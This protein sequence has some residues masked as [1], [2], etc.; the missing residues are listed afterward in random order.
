MLMHQNVTFL[1]GDARSLAMAERLSEL[2]AL[3]TIYALRQPRKAATITL[4]PTL[5]SA[6]QSAK[7]VVLPMPAFDAQ[8]CV[9]CPL[10]SEEQ[11]LPNAAALLSLI[12][13]SVPVF[14]GRI[15]PAAFALACDLAVRMSDYSLTDEVLIRNAVPTAEGAI[16]LA[17]Q[18]LDVT[19]H[20]ARAAVIGF[21]RVGFALATRLHALG[22]HVTVAVRKTRDA[23]RAEGMGCRSHLLSGQDSVRRLVEDGY[24]VVFNTVPYQLISCDTLL[25]IPPHTVLIELASAPGGWDASARANCKTIYAPGLPAKCAPRT[26]GIILADALAAMLEEVL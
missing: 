18:A 9:P 11:Q 15:S 10:A 16:A 25:R 14:G 21:G 2:G 6:L 23:A 1:G 13:S 26:A 7:A 22:A 4:A 3:V 19:L 12:G 8:L 24:D 20:G 17:M 5:D